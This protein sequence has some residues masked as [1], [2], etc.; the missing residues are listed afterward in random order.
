MQSWL[1]QRE[2]LP[3]VDSSDSRLHL[4]T[5]HFASG[6]SSNNYGNDLPVFLR[7]ILA[8][9]YGNDLSDSNFGTIELQT[10]LTHWPERLLSK[11]MV[12]TNLIGNIILQCIYQIA[13][14]SR[15]A[16]F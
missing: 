2:R 1:L 10:H 4:K 7:D 15:L 14:A 9:N 13:M 5:L 6:I 16:Y 3:I 12:S 11:L 8:N